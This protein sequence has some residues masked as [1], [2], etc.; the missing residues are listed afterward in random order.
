VA[1]LSHVAQWWL[2]LCL[3]IDS[4]QLLIEARLQQKELA[5]MMATYSLMDQ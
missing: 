1:V 5:M 3:M 4:A 2:S